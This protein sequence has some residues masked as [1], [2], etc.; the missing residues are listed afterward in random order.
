MFFLFHLSPFRLVK[1]TLKSSIVSDNLSGATQLLLLAHTPVSRKV[2][3][4]FYCNDMAGTVLMRADYDIDCNSQI[5]F[6][7]MYFVLVVMAGFTILLPGT[8]SY[9][10]WNHWNDLYSTKTN[11]RIGWLYEPFVRGAEFW[12]V[13]DL[14]M[15]MV[16]TGMLIYVPPTS[17]AGVAIIICVICCCNLNYFEPHKN[18]VI[19]WLSQVSFITTTFKYTTGL[20]LTATTDKQDMVYVGYLLIFL[21]IFFIF[22]S[23]L[24]II[25]SICMVRGHVKKIKHMEDKNHPN[26][27]KINNIAKIKAKNKAAKIYDSHIRA[28]GNYFEEKLASR[29]TVTNKFRS[30]KITPTPPKNIQEAIEVESF[31]KKLFVGAT[32]VEPFETPEDDQPVENLDVMF[33]EMDFE[34]GGLLDEHDDDPSDGL[35]VPIDDGN[36]EH[37]QE[38]ADE[39]TIDGE[40]SEKKPS[41]E[42]F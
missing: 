12:Q 40:T 42:W 11:Q 21:D 19:F 18:K 10:L 35:H 31:E 20:L 24:C 5:Y 32:E 9:Y 39:E 36:V 41:S 27:K 30:T 7:F 25:I 14:M 4:Y 1:W 23:G 38:K 8:I 13:H 17:R 2:F 16:L 29:I 34:I 6:N 37:E 22:S 26:A 15:K 3:Q 33:D 28:S